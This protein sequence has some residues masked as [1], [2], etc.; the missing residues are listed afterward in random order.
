MA[1]VGRMES[2]LESPE[3]TTKR[4]RE[5]YKYFVPPGAQSTVTKSTAPDTV[6]G[7]H[8]QLVAWRL[9]ADRSMVSLIDR[10]EQYFIAESSKTLNLEDTTQSDNP[11]DAIWA[12]CISVPKAGR[13]CEHTLQA[14][15]ASSGSPAYF[16]VCDLQQDS[17][18]NTLEFVTHAPF[19]RYYCGVPLM[20]KN[21]IPI[22]SIFALDTKAREPISAS[23][24]SF[25][26][27][28]AD[29]CMT[30]LESL[31]EKEDAKRSKQMNMCLAAFVDPEN[32][33]R[34]KRIR[35]KNRSRRSSSNLKAPSAHSE[36]TVPQKESSLDVHEQVAKDSSSQYSS[37]SEYSNPK[38]EDD[39]YVV[40]FKT[41]TNLLCNSLELYGNSGVV[42]LDTG[43]A[44]LQTSTI[45]ILDE[46][47]STKEPVGSKPI[48]R[49]SSTN[50]THVSFRSD[51]H[52]AGPGEFT[53]DHLS[54]ESE[55]IASSVKPET[56]GPLSSQSFAFTPLPASKLNRL[57]KSYPRGML[58]NLEDEQVVASSS[59]G[60]EEQAKAYKLPRTKDVN[61]TKDE[62]NLLKTHFPEARQLIF[63]PVWNAACS[64][65][66][67]FFGVNGNQ[68]RTFQKSPEFLHALAFCHCITTELGRLATTAADQ[69]KSDFIGSI[70]HE[71]RSPLHG[72]LASCEFMDDTELS[73]FQKSL[74]DTADSCARTLLDTINMV[75][76]YSKINAFERNSKSSRKGK[77]E[78]NFSMHSQPAMNI[79][80]DVDLAAITEEVVEGVATG[81]VFKDRLT[82]VDNVDLANEPEVAETAESKAA[83]S[84]DIEIMIDMPPGHWTFNTQPGAF[85][86]VVMNVFG[87]ALKYTSR[88]YIR[89]S[90][91]SEPTVKQSA[92][93]PDIHIVTL[94]ITDTG[95]GIGKK[96]ME[97]MLFT[98]FAQESSIA[99]G[100]GLGLSL[101]RS[102]IRMLNGEIDIKS[103]VGVGTEVVM[104][105]PMTASMS[106]RSDSSSKTP[107]SISN[108]TPST[109]SS[110]ERTKDDSLKVVRERAGQRTAMY[111]SSGTAES[112]HPKSPEI[113]KEVMDKYLAGWYDFNIITAFSEAESPDII[114]V[115]QAD[116][117]TL[118]TIR[119]GL[120]TRGDAPMVIVVCPNASSFN[121]ENQDEPGMNR[122]ESISYPFGPYK[123]AK[124]IRICLDNIDKTAAAAESDTAE[125]S[126]LSVEDQSRDE[127]AEVMQSVDNMTLGQGIN[128]VQQGQIMA[129]AE[130]A[131]MMVEA[132]SAQST[133]SIEA[134]SGFPFPPAMPTDTTITNPTT[135]SPLALRTPPTAIPLRPRADPKSPGP[136]LPRPPSILPDQQ[137]PPPPPALSPVPRKPR[138]LLVDDNAVNLRLLNT[139]MSKKRHY[140]DIFT[141]T[142]GALAVDAYKSMINSNPPKPPDIIFM[143]ITMPVKNGFQATREIRDLENA[144]R[145]PLSPMDTPPQTMIIALTG[146]A[147]SRD[148]NEAFT[149]GFDLYLVK[150]ISFKSVA[151]LLDSWERKSGSEAKMVPHGPV[152]AESSEAL[153]EAVESQGSTVIS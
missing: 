34:R 139:F 87:N 129:N 39:D 52:R 118:L 12:G 68:Y 130:F 50:L 27:N 21:G 41:A 141:A 58:F 74:V 67:A 6:L 84:P 29:N 16:E 135:P 44:L 38:V 117:S 2:I 146:L 137:K 48:A 97:T 81:Q 131:N 149:S 102:I 56:S 115:P 22:G 65:Y 111:F 121:A 25:L 120:L 125:D 3:V 124:I 78:A 4:S 15:P 103:S 53:E 18:F 91:T 54:V 82:D 19:F 71:L 61:A 23:R 43:T 93:A 30:H 123:L 138:L 24:I 147:S 112:A 110:L 9:N 151:K 70:S 49:R 32:R 116:F 90:L 60:E 64:R 79:Y 150:P 142:D 143:D 106:E 132:L 92:D 10:D 113:M 66:C 122:V 40:T 73:T 153:A 83:Q 134:G 136:A 107:S 96:Y 62:T 7:A 100:T 37:A 57:I 152:T 94:K 14:L 11:E 108:M 77:R 1:A 55:I 148:Q 109:G 105:F 33:V 28:M 95:Q 8:A 88:G 75:L 36:T 63:V 104:A 72:I 17:R 46:L 99:P 20:T 144:Y 47:G 42:F 45:A 133:R 89:V 26:A 69:Q 59:S 140:T 98:P 80:G 85:R 128:I 13:L 127:M 31:R 51:N 5:L 126:G 35:R 119:P 101:V 145:E 86:R 76:D 114:V